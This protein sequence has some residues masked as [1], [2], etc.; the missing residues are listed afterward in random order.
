MPA[1]PRQPQGTTGVI[2]IVRQN[3]SGNQSR[4]SEFLVSFGGKKDGVGAFWLGRATSF[5]PPTAMLRKLGVP[6]T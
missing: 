5:D 3:R 6:S 4:A 2:H 1:E